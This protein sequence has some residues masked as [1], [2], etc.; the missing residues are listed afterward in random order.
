MTILKNIEVMSS[1]YTVIGC[2][3]IIC[4]AFVSIAFVYGTVRDDVLFGVL[5]SMFA[6]MSSVLVILFATIIV[7]F[8][9]KDFDH[10]RYEVIFDDNTSINE[11]YKQYKIVD[12]DQGVFVIEE[13]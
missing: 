5:L 12:Y 2:I 13:R 1:D 3:V 8:V 7:S 4:L 6:I 11:V 10:Y 9:N